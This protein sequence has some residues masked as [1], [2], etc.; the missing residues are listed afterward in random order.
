MLSLSR[1]LTTALL[2]PRR[3]YSASHTS[4]PEATQPTSGEKT[5]IDTLTVKFSPSQLLVQDISGGC[6][7]FYAIT[8]ASSAF[9]DLTTLKQHRMVQTELKDVIKS[10]HGLQLKTIPT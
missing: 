8:I 1:R 6:G 2:T 10:I 5:I 9:K 4:P 7:D 3:L